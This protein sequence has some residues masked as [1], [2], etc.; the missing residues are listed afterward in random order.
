VILLNIEESTGMQ[1]P[2]KRV[3]AYLSRHGVESRLQS[4]PPMGDSIADDILDGALAE[5]ATCVIMG[6]YSHNRMGEY[7]FGGVT[8][9][10]LKACPIPLV[11]AH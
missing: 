11:V 6:G 3:R 9:T 10:L 7:L 1:I 5:G 2:A 4:R 8:R